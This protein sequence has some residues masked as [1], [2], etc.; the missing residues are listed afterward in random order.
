M[1]GDHARWVDVPWGCGAA[2]DL[3]S[4]GETAL[5]EENF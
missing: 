4:N 5:T 1:C 3:T 2:F